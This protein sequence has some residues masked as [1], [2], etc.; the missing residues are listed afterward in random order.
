MVILG[1]IIKGFIAVKDSFSSEKNPVEEQ[2]KVLKML[3]TKA[4]KTAFGQHYNFESLL[5]AENP[6]RAFAEKVPYFDYNKMQ[7]EWWFRLQNGEEDVTW[8]GHPKYFALSSGTTG[9]S[10]KRIPVPASFC[11]E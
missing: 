4:K 9:K 6:A 2:D 5:E 7:E 11:I 1:N 8:P 10:S 3:L